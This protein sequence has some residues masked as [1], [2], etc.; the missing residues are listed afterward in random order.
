MASGAGIVLAA[1]ALI[2][3][4]IHLGEGIHK[5]AHNALSFGKDAELFRVSF[6]HERRRLEAIRKV[7]LEK[8]FG[9]E[10]PSTIFEQFPDDWQA[11]LFDELRQLRILYVELE[12]IEARYGIFAPAR[13]I[14]SGILPTDALIDLSVND[15]REI[16]LQKSVSAKQLSV[17]AL[18]DSKRTLDLMSRLQQWINRYRETVAMSVSHIH[19]GVY[20]FIVRRYLWAYFDDRK[21][22]EQ[23]QNDGDAQAL[24]LANAA[25]LRQII[26]DQI[27]PGEKLLIR[28]SDIKQ[29][30]KLRHLSGRLYGAVFEHKNVLLEHKEYDRDADAEISQQT[31][32]LVGQLAAVLQQQNSRSLHVLRCH[33]Y[34]VDAAHARYTFVYKVSP[35]HRPGEDAENRCSDTMV[36]GPR[37]RAGLADIVVE[38]HLGKRYI[39]EHAEASFIHRLHPVGDLVPSAFSRLGPQESTQRERFAFPSDF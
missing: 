11:D 26:L 13:S 27:R 17:W 3:P 19:I 24:D 6:N 33:G 30:T 10:N 18:R 31:T 5:S 7:L 37:Q 34:F 15:R 16:D 39:Q 35:T 29:Q 21:R 4:I 38:C 20:M 32:E 25:R 8:E 28:P 12:S 23:L 14:S 22:L 1:I 36:T 2:E 9:P